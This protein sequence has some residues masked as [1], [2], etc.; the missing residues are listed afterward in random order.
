M[1]NRPSRRVAQRAVGGGNKGNLVSFD[2]TRYR[3]WREPFINNEGEANTF[4]GAPP[5]ALRGGTRDSGWQTSFL[6]RVC[7]TV[8]S[9]ATL[10]RL[11]G[12]FPPPN[13]R[14]SRRSDEGVD[15]S[16]SCP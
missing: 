9:V 11:S 13:T 3:G 12:A 8:I 10:S 16:A 7:V 6:E 4:R 5:R 1:R 15:I 2:Y 14:P